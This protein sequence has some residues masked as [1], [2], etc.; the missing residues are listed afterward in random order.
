MG[1]RT[2]T[3][4]GMSAAFVN[5]PRSLA[6]VDNSPERRPT[7]SAGERLEVLAEAQQRVAV[8]ANCTVDEALALMRD[9]AELTDRT[10]YDIA[11]AV[12][13]HRTWFS[14]R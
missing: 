11:D 5:D 1:Q 7:R 8:Q 6:R 2:R 12:N 4:N 14:Q 13:K 10:V 9:R 3:V